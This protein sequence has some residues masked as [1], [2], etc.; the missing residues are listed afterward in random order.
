MRRRFISVFTAITLLMPLIGSSAAETKTDAPIGLGDYVSMGEYDTDGDGTAEPIL[1][2]CVAFEKVISTDESGN[3]I[4]DATNTSAEYKDGYL[5]LMLADQG[6]CEKE[7]DA[8]GSV[9]T[10][11]HGRESD[12]D[13][14]GSPYW[15]DSNIRDWLNS[16][17]PAGNVTWSCGNAPSYKDE[18][19]FLTNFTG[20]EKDLIKTAAQKTLLDENDYNALPEDK[21]SGSVKMPDYK[22]MLSEVLPSYKKAYSELVTDKM[23][24]LDAQQ[25][26][27]V[28]DN[29]G[30]YF[31]L[32]SN[33]WIKSHREDGVTVMPPKKVT[34]NDMYY[35]SPYWDDVLVRP[36]FY[37]NT[38]SEGLCSGNSSNDAVHIMRYQKKIS[39]TPKRDGI[40][41]HYYCTG[42]GKKSSDKNGATEIDVVIPAGTQLC[43]NIQLG[44]YVQMGTYDKNNDGTA[45]PILWR[46][47]GFEKVIGTDESGNPIIDSAQ[48]SSEPKDGYLPLLLA[49]SWVCKKEVDA[50]GSGGSHDRDSNRATYGARPIGQTA[51]SVTGLIRRLRQAT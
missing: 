36:A 9:I 7:F 40:K 24:L 32:S 39:A 43:G 6:I 45:E 44:D 28:R 2:R 30:E 31:R 21:R 1:W 42:C 47:V 41:E 35:K 38:E 5:P 34:S 29:Y 19:G 15:A 12:R 4:T 10:G 23:F 8:K 50:A 33:Y 17:A 46:C 11:S 48:S 51:I 49:D 13:R 25:V 14:F 18:A 3:P 16:S 27:N 20:A 26:Q 37:L 22:Y